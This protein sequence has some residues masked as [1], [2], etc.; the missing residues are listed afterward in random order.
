MESNYVILSYKIT[1][2]L[3]CIVDAY[4]VM[5]KPVKL[6]ML[7]ILA[8]FLVLQSNCQNIDDEKDEY[9]NIYEVVVNLTRI[10]ENP[11][12]STHRQLLETGILYLDKLLF[13][14]DEVKAGTPKAER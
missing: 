2:Q 10:Y 6:Q 7:L 14:E 5:I 3:Y 1:L 4:A 9:D 11:K 8:V 12:M 13:L